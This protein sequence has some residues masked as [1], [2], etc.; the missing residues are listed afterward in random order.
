MSP[1]SASPVTERAPILTHV[2]LARAF[3]AGVV[4]LGHTLDMANGGAHRMGLGWTAPEIN[5]GF[6]V[7]VFFVVSGLIMVHTAGDWFAAPEAPW[8]FLRLR[9]IRIVPLYWLLTLLWIVLALALPKML[10][11]PLGGGW[12]IF[13]S[14]AFLPLPRPN[15]NGGP[16]LAQGWT[17]G[18]EMLFYLLFA[19]G[20]A[21]RRSR[22][23]ALIIGGIGVLS[24]LGLAFH[25]GQ[26]PWRSWTDP[27]MLEFLF[28]LGLALWLKER[29]PQPL[30]IS[31]GLAGAGFAL[32]L[33]GHIFVAHPDPMVR[34]LWNGVPALLVVAG[35]ASRGA[36]PIPRFSA[37][38]AVLGDASYSLYLA[39][40]FVVRAVREVWMRFVPGLS[41]SVFV[42][43]AFA[44]SCIAAVVI[45]RLIEQPV[46]RWLRRAADR[47]SV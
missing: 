20:L 25:P 22:G 27:L 26:D 12:V 47:S 21:Y 43:V 41:P 40:P 45:Y 2:Q 8:R 17:L 32:F 39:H 18:Y 3:A 4:V 11:A 1:P 23:L 28:G 6:G 10:A 30:A 46:T 14:F 7:D 15:G 44:A 19:A 5:Y 29:D 33:L 38:L 16:V 34:W 9:L 36:L 42:P 31:L 35:A 13:G 24:L 37:P